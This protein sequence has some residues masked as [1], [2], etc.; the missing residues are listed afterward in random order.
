MMGALNKVWPWQANNE[1]MLPHGDTFD[2][3]ISVYCIYFFWSCFILFEIKMRKFGLIGYPL[4][5]SFSKSYFE[6]NSTSLKIDDAS[7]E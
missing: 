2:I 6:K 4:K 1:I 5:H 7:Y 3:A